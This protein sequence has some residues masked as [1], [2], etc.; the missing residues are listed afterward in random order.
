MKI[1][2]PKQLI[3]YPIEVPTSKSISNRLLM[4]QA[5]SGLG[6]I[7]DLSNAQDTQTLNALLTNMPAVMDVGHAGTAFRFLTAF[8]TIQKGT[9][10]LTGSDRMKQRPIQVLVD[11]LRQLGADITYLENE[12]FPPLKIKGG[13]ILKGTIKVNARISSQFISALMMIGPY[14]D[15]GL[16]IQLANEPVSKPYI[17]MTAQLMRGCGVE[18]MYTNKGISIPSGAYSFSTY[19]I[20]KDWS[21]IGFWCELVVISKMS[22]LL[23]HKVTTDS[24]Q[25]DREVLTLFKPLGLAS[26][27]DYKGLHLRF[28]ESVI[29]KTKK[30]IDFTNSPDLVQPFV[31]TLAGISQSQTITG[32]ITL[33][34]KETDRCMALKKE[35]LQFG[36]H[37]AYTENKMKVKAEKF[38]N[39]Q[40]IV[41]TYQDHRMAMA[42]APLAFKCGELNIQNPEVVNKSYPQYWSQLQKLGFQCTT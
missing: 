36:S 42:F 10:L 13:T 24:I 18:V 40:E 41:K 35:L 9:Y 26:H 34:G 16:E 5:M 4:M 11:A 7:K 33:K 21:S 31:A 37:L 12:G 29:S 6:E 14:V 19:T 22:H 15:N 20:E 3:D 2:A 28:D 27:F 8:L 30:S 32:I 23:I 38:T 39:P 25:G 17:E 1:S